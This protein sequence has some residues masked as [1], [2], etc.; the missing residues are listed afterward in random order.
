MNFRLP[1]QFLQPSYLHNLPSTSPFRSS[2]SSSVVTLSP[3]QPS[4]HWKSQIAHLDMITSFLES[5]SRF[6][7]SALFISS[8]T[9]QPILVN[10]SSLSI[11]HSFT[12]SL[13]TQNLPLQQILPILTLHLIGFRDNGTGPNL[14]CSSVYFLIFFL[15]HLFVTT[16]NE[17]KVVT[18]GRMSNIG[19]E[20]ISLNTG[21]M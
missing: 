7:S 1:T 11:Y 15:L 21:I 12:L 2:H 5:A 14:S 6:I 8:F 19:Q 20:E 16:R 17:Q 10:I 13:Q 18:D 4:P 9:C 3:N